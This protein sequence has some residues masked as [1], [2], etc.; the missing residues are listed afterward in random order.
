MSESDG[1]PEINGEARPETTE[2]TDGAEPLDN[3]E[4]ESVSST[5]TTQLPFAHRSQL[6]MIQ[7]WE[8]LTAA[9]FLIGLSVGFFVGAIFGTAYMQE[10]SIFMAALLGGVLAVALQLTIIDGIA[11]RIRAFRRSLRPYKYAPDFFG[12]AIDN[13]S[14]LAI[15]AGTMKWFDENR[16]SSA[17]DKLKERGGHGI[18]L[19]CLDPDEKMKES[20][21]RAALIEKRITELYTKYDIRRIMYHSGDFKGL[22]CDDV[23]GLLTHEPP[24]PG[25]FKRYRVA[26]GDPPDYMIYVDEPAAVKALWELVEDFS[27]R[28]NRPPPPQVPFESS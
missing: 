15:F 13:Y 26:P 14:R 3:G 24:P 8:F 23:F 9:R 10:R 7:A 11:P 12:A 25:W 1:T 2:A 16:Y 22:L 6:L 5:P 20:A 19:F 27:E 4:N 18:Y 21:S 28:A 17:I